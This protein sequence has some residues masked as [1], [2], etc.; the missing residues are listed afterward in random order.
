M[1]LHVLGCHGGELPS[2]RTTCFL[3]DDVLALDAGALTSTLTLE[4]LCK[5][6][7]ILVG[8][9]HFDHVKDLPLLADLVIGRR[10][11]PVTIHASRECARS[12][13]EY[14]FNN[15]LWPDFTRIPTKKDPVLRIK[16]F[17]AGS[18]FQVGRYTVQSIPV[19]H[20]VESC[21]F[22]VSNGQSSLAM[23]GDT[24]PTEK[25]WKALNQAKNLKALLLETSFP[26]ALQQLAD[27]SGHLTPRTL[28]SELTKFERNGTDVLLYHLKPAFVSQ[29]KR[30]LAELP[31]NI[32]ELG[33]TFEF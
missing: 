13:R 19:S 17:R 26:N 1:K 25:L 11:T 16:A 6:D 28:Q 2:C 23:S 5:V 33:D 31:V 24:G 30:E 14:M 12:L 15:A 32:L 8:H 20:P 27:L 22:I 9:S 10:D 3:V 18:T 7:D 29:L 4:Q 21:A